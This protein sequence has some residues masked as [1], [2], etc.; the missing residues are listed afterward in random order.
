MAKL[1]ALSW[2]GNAAAALGGVWGSVSRRAREAG[3]SRQT[4]YEHG[5][6]VAQAVEASQFPGRSR[7]ELAAEVAGLLEENRQLW[8]WL[9]QTIEF[10]RERQEQFAATGAAMG[11]SVSQVRDLLQIVLGQP[12]PGRSTLG[13]WINRWARRAGEVLRLIDERCRRLV[14]QMCVDEIFCR[15]TPVLMAVEPASMTWLV[16]QRGPNRTGATWYTVLAAWLA[17]EYVVA[18]GGS[19]IRAGVEQL[20]KERRERGESPL[21]MN[22]DVFHIQQEAAR[23]MRHQWQHAEAV[24][25]KAVAQEKAVEKRRRQGRNTSRHNRGLRAAWDKAQTALACVDRQ[26]QAWQQ[27]AQALEVFTPEGRLNERRRAEAQIATALPELA[28]ARWAKVRRFLQD[29]RCLTFLDRLHRHLQQAEPD[30]ELREA[31]VHLWWL[32]RHRPRSE[33]GPAA[34]HLAEPLQALICAKQA[35]HWQAAYRRVAEALRQAVRASSV[36]ECLNSVTRMH[37]ARHRHLTQELLDL[38]RLHWN[39]RPF[40]E[41]KRR[42]MCPYGLLGLRLPTFD[43]WKLLTMPL[44]DLAQQLSTA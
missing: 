8:E 16:G 24:W 21:E 32:R 23:V 30:E 42:R 2:I 19:G 31:L 6:R 43:W 33:E 34:A 22:L 27:A 40:R 20:Q 38:K 1:S 18:D 39:C 15:R 29:Q 11:L 17:L 28:D 41:G 37:Q 25:D 36:V 9:D 44:T 13:E 5:R 4:V 35:P 26:E 3:C 14:R 10:P 12:C 7:A